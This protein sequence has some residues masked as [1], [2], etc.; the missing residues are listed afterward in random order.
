LRGKDALGKGKAMVYL[1]THGERTSGPDPV[2]TPN[3]LDQIK[4]LVPLIPQNIALIVAGTGKRFLEILEIVRQK[5]PK[6]EVKYSPF[7]GGPEGYEESDIVVLPGG[8]RVDYHKEYLG[9]SNGPVDMWQFVWTLPPNT[10]LCS[11]G[12][13]MIGL[14]LKS[15]NQ[16]AQL[17]E[18][19]PDINDGRK[20]S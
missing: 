4:T 8:R 14:G 3:G 1:I 10:L 20:I 18:L 13:L 9:I 16:R 5:L 17:Y 11:G 2:H 19:N 12:A 15:I 6:A 7:C